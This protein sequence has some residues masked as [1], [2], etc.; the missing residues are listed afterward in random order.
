MAHYEDL[1]A[2]I[3]ENNRALKQLTSQS[4]RLERS[5]RGRTRG[6]RLNHLRKYALDIYKAVESAFKCKCKNQHQAGL[7]LTRGDEEQPQSLN[8]HGDHPFKVL[9]SGGSMQSPHDISWKQLRL[10]VIAM[11]QNEPI[12]PP[13]LSVLQTKTRRVGF[14]DQMKSKVSVALFREPQPSSQHLVLKS[15]ALA[16]SSSK[17]HPDPAL[18]DS[19]MTEQILD[20]C[21][22]LRRNTSPLLGMISDK[23]TKFMVHCPVQ[24]TAV[25]PRRTVSL[26]EI[27]NGKAPALPHIPFMERLHMAA[28]VSSAVLELHHTP[29]MQ[30]EPSKHSILVFA[31]SRRL[32]TTAFVATQIK[33]LSPDP[34]SEEN[35]TLPPYIENKALFILGILLIELLFGASIE[36]LRTDKDPTPSSNK[37]DWEMKY[38]IATRLLKDESILLEGGPSYE[39]AVRSCIKCNFDQFR[40]MNLEEDEFRQAVYERVV[41]VLE[42]IPRGFGQAT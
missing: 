26:G 15:T 10:E 3:K 28:T 16:A 40:N 39:S 5:R 32:H 7:S 36:T 42:D 35:E 41:A 31:D 4:I 33:D 22:K 37:S 29:W 23:Y 6:L 27:L 1:V 30:S 8:L 21:E 9:V 11:A 2:R 12:S 38:S 14:T 34:I 19:S 25:L 20:L 18:K 17:N 13:V 24:P